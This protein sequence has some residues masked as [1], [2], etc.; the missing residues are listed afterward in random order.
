MDRSRIPKITFEYNP[1]AEWIWDVQEMGSVK[2]EQAK[3][4]TL[5]RKMIMIMMI[6]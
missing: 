1:K 6:R 2:S 5:E 3:G 4:L